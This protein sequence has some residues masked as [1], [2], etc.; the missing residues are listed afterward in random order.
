MWREGIYYLSA[1]ASLAGS[2][3]HKPSAKIFNQETSNHAVVHVLLASPRGK[4]EFKNVS[5]SFFLAMLSM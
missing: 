1:N 2:E 3:E 4:C 5:R